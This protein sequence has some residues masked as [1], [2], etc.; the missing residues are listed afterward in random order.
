MTFKKI[1]GKIHLW[2]GLL[3]GLVVFIVSLTGCIF[4]FEEELFNV[5]HPQ[6]VHVEVPIDRTKTLPVS[7]L[8]KIA[9]E[10]LGGKD[11]VTLINMYPE[12]NRA[13]E[14]DV[15]RYDEKVAQASFW[16]QAGLY[17]K[18]A[19]IDPFT[20]KVNGIMD[21]Q[22]EFFIVVR[23]IHQNLFLKH[24][25]GSF[26]VGSSTIIFVVLLI[27]GLVLWWPKNKAAAKQRYAFRWKD[28][29]QWKRKN[30]DL[31][32][33]LGF[34]AL[35][36]CLFIALTGIVWSFDW[37][38]NTVYRILDGKVVRFK[39]P[40]NPNPVATGS[41]AT[42]L[43]DQVTYRI[44][45]E[46][47]EY[48]RIFLSRNQATNTLMAGASFKDNSLWSPHSYHMY[49]LSTGKE[50]GK[51]LQE[52]KTTGQKWRNSNYDLHTGKTLGYPGMILAFFVSLISASLP[53]TGFWIWWG[54]RKK[55]VKAPVKA[56]RT[57]KPVY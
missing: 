9:F 44:Q 33:I 14:F 17:W 11:T 28:T 29:T 30:Y 45:K 7:A 46:N 10:A 56:N 40:Q 1:T 51:L 24:E 16:D 43:L 26:I 35:I 57:R 25:I 27:S 55:T 39:L 32:N 22:Y 34:Y 47:P 49:D 19:Y 42:D 23:A 20:G 54:R 37:W 53:V 2:L 52:Q 5:F 3:S 13:W 8:R 31:H 36:L 50:F 21:M 6:L 41:E 38:E 4:A 12:K 48:K 18:K 15:F